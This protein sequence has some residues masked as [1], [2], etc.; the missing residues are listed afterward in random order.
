M[1]LPSSNCN[2]T[3]SLKQFLQGCS[4]VGSHSVSS[5]EKEASW[6]KQIGHSRETPLPDLRELSDP[7][8]EEFSRDSE[9]RID[10]DDE[11]SL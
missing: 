9:T 10:E 1:Q 8:D 2:L 6:S 5:W 3:Y 7:R 11:G 4:Q